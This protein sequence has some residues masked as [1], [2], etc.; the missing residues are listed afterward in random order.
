MLIQ[1][2]SETQATCLNMKGKIGILISGSA[3]ALSMYLD[4]INKATV[5]VDMAN[6]SKDE[7]LFDSIVQDDFWCPCRRKGK[8]H[9]SH[10]L[11]LS[12]V[13]GIPRV[14]PEKSKE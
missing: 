10:P 14:I 11:V 8:S 9:R 2:G 1:P 5:F 6:L 13:P 7:F 12:R 4:Q 3:P